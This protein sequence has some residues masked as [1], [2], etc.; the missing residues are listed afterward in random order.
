MEIVINNI[1]DYSK[2]EQT[3]IIRETSISLVENNSFYE[4]VIS[5]D[6]K[7]ISEAI[8]KLSKIMFGWKEEYVGARKIDGEKYHVIV[9]INHKKKKYKIQNKFPDNWEDFLNVKEQIMEGKFYD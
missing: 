9:D 6:S 2:K 1:K 8:N 4:N 5:E 3:I 7:F